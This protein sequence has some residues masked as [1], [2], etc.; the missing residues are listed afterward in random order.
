MSMIEQMVF[1]R[2]EKYR[3]RFVLP[4]EETI[5]LFIDVIK[6]SIEFFNL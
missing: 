5:E 4:E 2:L 6:K 3:E 1:K